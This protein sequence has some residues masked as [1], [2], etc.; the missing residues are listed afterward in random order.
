[1]GER[2]KEAL[3]VGFDP[4]V[5]IEFRGSRITSDAGLLAFRELDE[6]LG[7]TGIGCQFLADTRTGGNTRHTLLAQLR[8]SVYS[9]LAGYEDT[10]DAEQLCNDPAMRR[11]VGGSALA[12]TAAS[13]SQMDWFE[14]DVLHSA[15]TYGD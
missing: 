15:R 6:A 12:H 3:R 11:V 4:S 14:T 5:K 2:R 10:N 1:M 8:Q 9:R 13:T 7:L